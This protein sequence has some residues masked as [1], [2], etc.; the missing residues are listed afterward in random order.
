MKLKWIFKP[1]F[2]IYEFNFNKG[3]SLTVMIII[4]NKMEHYFVL[5]LVDQDYLEEI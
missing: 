2:L 3:L 4:N 5:D 1:T